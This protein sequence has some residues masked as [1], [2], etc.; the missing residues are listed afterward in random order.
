[1]NVL[2][3]FSI[4]LSLCPFIVSTLTRYTLD[5]QTDGA[6]IKSI[7]ENIVVNPG[8]EAKLSCAVDGKFVG[9]LFSVMISLYC[10]LMGFVLRKFFHGINHCNGKIFLLYLVEVI[11]LLQHTTEVLTF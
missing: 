5:K 6:T 8:D 1:M 7:S 10:V 3:L 11:F 4:P 9:K 2:L